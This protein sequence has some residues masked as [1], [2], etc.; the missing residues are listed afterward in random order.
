MRFR[1][2]RRFGRGRFHRISFRGR[3]HRRFGGMRRMRLRIGHRM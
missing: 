2:H 1:R 3:R